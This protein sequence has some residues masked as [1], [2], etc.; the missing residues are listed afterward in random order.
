M[1]FFTETPRMEKA[2]RIRRRKLR[3]S[4]FRRWNDVA[5]CRPCCIDSENL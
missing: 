3:F 1:L 5:W 4:R 2:N